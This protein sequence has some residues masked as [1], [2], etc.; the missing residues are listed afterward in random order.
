MKFVS[1][2]CI[3]PKYWDTLNS[4]HASPKICTILPHGPLKNAEWLADNVDPDQTS[5]SEVS[6]ACPSGYLG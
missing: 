6:P 3:Y 1:S 4:Y 2:Y 5:Y